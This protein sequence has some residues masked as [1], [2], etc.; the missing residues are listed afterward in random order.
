MFYEI[1][2][3]PAVFNPLSHKTTWLPFILL[4]TYDLGLFLKLLNVYGFIKEWISSS[5]TGLQFPVL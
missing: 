1:L 4:H 3:G 2:V 5:A